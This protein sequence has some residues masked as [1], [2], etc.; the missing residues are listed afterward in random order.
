M[1]VYPADRKEDEG[2][3]NIPGRAST[4][5]ESLEVASHIL[6]NCKVF[7][8]IGASVTYC[9]AQRWKSLKRQWTGAF[10]GDHTLAGS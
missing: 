8:L 3:E 9:V 2:K 1:T 7:G 5:A 6:Q 4:K 10:L